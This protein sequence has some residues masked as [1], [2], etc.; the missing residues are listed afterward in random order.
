MAEKKLKKILMNILGLEWIK[1][2]SYHKNN[3]IFLVV[4]YTILGI[5]SFY[6]LNY[7]TYNKISADCVL[8]F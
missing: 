4:G 8:K 2:E 3:F 1:H 6:S 5:F 7:N